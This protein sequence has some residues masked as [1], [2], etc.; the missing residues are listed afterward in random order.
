MAR[1]LCYIAH[2]NYLK[3][4]LIKAKVSDIR[5]HGEAAGIDGRLIRARIASMLKDRVFLSR[6]RLPKTLERIWKREYRTPGKV[7]PE[8]LPRYALA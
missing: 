6:I 7:K 2:H 1:L 5:V 3:R 8:Y 4:Y